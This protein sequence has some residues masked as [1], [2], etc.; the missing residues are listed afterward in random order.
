[1]SSSSQSLLSSPLG[2]SSVVLAR[3]LKRPTG[4][5]EGLEELLVVRL[6]VPVS[7][8]PRAQQ[9][10]RQVARTVALLM[11]GMFCGPLRR[12]RIGHADNCALAERPRSPNDR[13]QRDG[14]VARVE[15]AI[16]L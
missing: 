13:V 4:Q 6:G 1:M 16:Q 8:F 12:L 9:Q 3:L 15:Q 7:V 11:A 5:G 14:D 10:G 2:L